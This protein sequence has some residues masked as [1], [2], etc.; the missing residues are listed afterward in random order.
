MFVSLSE[1][2]KPLETYLK[3]IRERVAPT[4]IGKLT[5]ARR[6]EYDV[7]ANW[8]VYVDNYLEGYHVPYVHPELY[9]SEER[10]VGKECR[11]R[12]SPEHEKKKTKASKQ[13]RRA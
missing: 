11:S 1:R 9:R 13:N 12:W 10:R 5:F 3:D 2:P 4:H 8:K 7:R 6:V